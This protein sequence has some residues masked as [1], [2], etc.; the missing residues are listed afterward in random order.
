MRY[1]PERKEAVLKKMMPPHARPISQLALE[2]AIS[3]ATLY[4]WRQ[5]ARQKGILLPDASI[6]PKGWSAQDKFSTVLETAAMN[7]SELAEYC[8]KKGI[9]PEQA[10][11]LS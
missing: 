8:R 10:M 5:Q 6:E 2:E 4:K 11:A 9:Y 3:K 7:E 1:T